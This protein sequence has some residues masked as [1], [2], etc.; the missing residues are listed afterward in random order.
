[1]MAGQI[2]NAYGRFGERCDRFTMIAVRF[3]YW[4]GRFVSSSCQNHNDDVRNFINGCQI[5]CLMQQLCYL[6]RQISNDMWQ[7][8][9]DICQICSVY[10]QNCNDMC[11]Q[12]NHMSQKN[13]VMWQKH[14]EMWHK[15]NERRQI[16]ND[17]VNESHDYI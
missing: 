3:V 7:K 17:N 2:V 16:D 15:I 1:M 14:N 11:Q 6:I 4:C 8:H 13:N 10:C 5:F 12:N 9:N